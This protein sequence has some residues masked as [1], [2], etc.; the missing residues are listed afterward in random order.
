[1]ATS[2]GSTPD[3]LD[4]F[5]GVGRL[6]KAFETWVLPM[7]AIFLQ[8]FMSESRLGIGMLMVFSSGNLSVAWKDS[9]AASLQRSALYSWVRA[10]H[11]TFWRTV[12]PP[13]KLLTSFTLFADASDCS[14]QPLLFGY[15]RFFSPLQGFGPSHLSSCGLELPC[16]TSRSW[17]SPAEMI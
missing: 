12:Q 13:A 15:G 4:G 9:D 11:L 2:R 7:D 16:M 10:D 1:M 17:N 5:S 6:S 8:R 3:I 14:G